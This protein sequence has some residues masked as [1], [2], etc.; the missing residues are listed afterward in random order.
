V[1]RADDGTVYV[2]VRDPDSNTLKIVRSAG[3]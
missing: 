2:E 1:E 3:D